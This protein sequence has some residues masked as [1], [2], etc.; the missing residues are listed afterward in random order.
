MIYIGIDFVDLYIF[1]LRNQGVAGGFWGS[2]LGVLWESFFVSEKFLPSFLV[3][4]FA[5]VVPLVCFRVV[6]G[7]SLLFF[8]FLEVSCGFSFCSSFFFFLGFR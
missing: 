1:F 6:R 7:W 4:L 3:P 2:P 5:F 8:L